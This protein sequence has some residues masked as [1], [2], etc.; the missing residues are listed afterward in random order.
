MTRSPRPTPMRSTRCARKAV[1]GALSHSTL[2]HRQHGRVARWLLWGLAAV[3]ALAAVLLATLTWGPNLMREQIA[4]R[5]SLMLGRTVHV[6]HIS[7]SPFAGHA[8]FS[9]LVIDSLEPGKPMLTAKRVDLKVDPLAYLHGV[10]V[11]RSIEMDEPRARIVRTSS[12]ALDLSDVVAQFTNR[13]ASLRRTDWRV[14]RV[15]LHNGAFAFD[16]RVVKKVTRIDGLQFSL[17]GLTNLEATIDQ[18][19]TLKA[20]FSLDDRPAALDARATLFS[21]A[22]AYD[23]QASLDALPLASVLPYVPLPADI[24]PTG[25]AIDLDL[26]SRYLTRPQQPDQA[27]SLEGRAGLKD[28]GV[29][30]AQGASRLSVRSLSADIGPSFP[31]GG[32]IRVATLALAGL[33]FSGGRAADGSMTWPKAGASSSAPAPAQPASPAQASAAPNSSGPALSGP[34]SLRIERVTVEDAAIQWADAALPG[35]LETKADP[36]TL[37]G[38]PILIPDLSQPSR[39]NGTAQLQT[40]INGETPLGVALELNGTQGQARVD[41]KRVPLARYAPLAGPALKAKVE[42][43]VIEAQG[44]VRWNTESGAWSVDG[45]QASLTDLRITH[46]RTQPLST[47]GLK[48]SAIKVD[49]AAQ[50]IEIGQARLERTNLS[51]FRDAGGLIDLQQ[52][53]DSGPPRKGPAARP[54]VNPPAD[55]AWSLLVRQAEVDRLEFDYR[56]ALIAKGNRLPR[57]IFSGKARDLTLDPKRTAPF[58]ATVSLADGSRLSAA[59]TVRPQPLNLNAQLR[60]QQ[61]DLT[62]LDPYIEPYLNLALVRGQLWGGGRLNLESLPN[63]SLSRIG[64][65]GEVS[66]N[67]VA[68]EDKLTREDFARW[69]ALAAPSV[70]VDWRPDRPGQSSIAIG[71]VAFVD[72]YARVILSQEGR[73][74]LSNILADPSRGKAPQSLTDSTGART[75]PPLASAA[76]TSTEQPVSAIGSGQRS[77]TV[78]ARADAKTAERPR[79][80]IGTIRVA[81][82]NVVFTDLFIRPNYTANLTQLSGS[83]EALASDRS[84]PSDVLISGRVD[85][86]TPLDITGKINPLAPRNYIDLRAVA[87]GFDLPKLSP[88]SGRWAGYAIEKGKLTANVRYKV[89]GDKLDAENKLVINQLT[90]G[91]KVESR[92]ALKLPVQ[93]AVSLLKDANG[94]IDLDLPI[95][96]TLSDPQFSVGGLIW[97]AIGN[98]IVKVVTS[99]FRFLASLGKEGGTGS[100]LSQIEFSAGDARIDD[101]DRRRLDGL[102]AALEA[103]P[104]LSL[105]IIG[106]ADPTSDAQALQKVRLERALQGT[107]LGDIRRTNK[108]TELTIETVTVDAT[109]RAALIERLWRAAKL[110]GSAQ[111]KAVSPEE[112]ERQLLERNEVATEDMRQLAQ[113]RA[114][115]VRNYLREERKVSTERLYVLAPRTSVNGEDKATE[116]ASVARKVTFE[117]K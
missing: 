17:E 15:A 32:E 66:A 104:A 103:R 41:L 34:R 96:G 78:S 83:I 113:R 84:E 40:S 60:L 21:E 112:M 19:A 18:P 3:L 23:V 80:S 72:F 46:P 63:G 53:Y 4:A 47:A 81:S 95:S 14:D 64:F 75:N 97:R 107:K 24:R 61:I 30:D 50:R 109:E 70:N 90:F 88:Y 110:D 87:R 115:T 28:V 16:D 35:G 10:V 68:A 31:L 99:P 44:L 114:E 38:G 92:D 51:A 93:L 108:A 39:L 12:G 100:D 2:K 117:V 48:L 29:A 76:P 5:T 22:P 98:L 9:N 43:G 101:E 37:T 8:V 26:R 94:N 116:T 77:A 67:N 56:D 73:L 59:G 85:D 33:N 65:A 62:Y 25:G 45:T 54:G 57:V 58:E 86:D 69:S 20:R 102:A 6:D 74:N 55:P 7:V 105:D 71:D 27:L 1:G 11:V 111:G 52:W 89:E 82:G 42:R 106:Y 13:P 91:E 36:V 79:V 49:G